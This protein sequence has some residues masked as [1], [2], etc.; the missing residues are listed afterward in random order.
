MIKP[1][2]L[3]KVIIYVQQ[4]RSH[5]CLSAKINIFK[6]HELF[7]QCSVKM[8]PDKRIVTLLLL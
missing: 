5:A 3:D 2:F 1:S 4:L 8:R 6:G 7:S